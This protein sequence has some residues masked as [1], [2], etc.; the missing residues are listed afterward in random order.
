MAIAFSHEP[1]ATMIRYMPD[2]AMAIAAIL[3]T[4]G[5][6]RRSRLGATWAPLLAVM[7]LGLAVLYGWFA[8][9]DPAPLYRLAGGRAMLAVVLLLANVA[10]WMAGRRDDG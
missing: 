2:W 4:A 1:Y 8:L 5:F 10:A 9:A 3:A 7:C 6:I